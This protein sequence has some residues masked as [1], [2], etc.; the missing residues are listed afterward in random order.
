MTEADPVHPPPNLPGIHE[1]LAVVA[2][3]R[4]PGGCPWDRAQTMASMAPHLVEE[5][6][7]AADALRRGI[8]AEAHEE[9]GDVLVNVAMISQMAREQGAFDVDAVAAA[10]ASKLVRRHPHVFGDTKV[11]GAEQ[12]YRSW[13]ASKRDERSEGRSVLA[14]V[15]VALPALLRAFRLGEKA[16]RAGFDWPDREGPRAKVAEELAELDAAIATSDSTAIASELGDLLF[17]ICNLAR[18]LA[19][20]PEVALASATDRFQRRFLAVEQEFGFRLQGRS[21]AEMDA[22]WNRAKQAERGE[23]H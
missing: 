6:F 4:D 17:S 21:L 19:V 8:V 10:A 7:E 12:A 18:H 16:A 22:A 23:A 14:G 5:A 9:L 11:D 15:P 13:E 2:R 1:L 3:L 20:N